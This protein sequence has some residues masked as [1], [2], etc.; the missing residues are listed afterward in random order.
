MHQVGSDGWIFYGN[1]GGPKYPVVTP[2]Y[3]S[4]MTPKDWQDRLYM[5]HDVGLFRAK[6]N[7]ERTAADWQLVQGLAS[8]A[9]REP[10]TTAT[11][12]AIAAA[13][14]FAIKASIDGITGGYLGY[15]PDVSDEL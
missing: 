11:A 15:T 8:G 1:Y 2:G 13:T 12:Y 5:Y 9:I 3:Q 4:Y 14:G 6:N 7:A 10:F